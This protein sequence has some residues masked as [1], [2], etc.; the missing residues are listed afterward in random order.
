MKT[1]KCTS[2]CSQQPPDSCLFPACILAHPKTR[3]SYCRIPTTHKFDS[4]CNVVAKK[5]ITPLSQLK[6][7]P[8][9]LL[10]G[11]SGECIAFGKEAYLL[12]DFFDEP[13][14]VYSV[15]Q[16]HEVL[17][18]KDGFVSYALIT[19]HPDSFHEYWV[20]IHYINRILSR[21]PCFLYT[22]GLFY[23]PPTNKLPPLEHSTSCDKIPY[24]VT[25]HLH[26]AVPMSSIPKKERLPLLFIIYH[27]LATLSSTFTH[28]HL[29]MKNV[30]VWRPHPT[31]YIQYNYSVKFQSPYLPKITHCVSS[32][33]GND[34][35]FETIIDPTQDVSL[36]RE[37][38]GIHL[39]AKTT[40][41]EVYRM[42]KR[43]MKSSSYDV[44]GTLTV[45]KTTNSF[46]IDRSF[47]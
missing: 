38:M 29:T 26:D 8:D 19:S 6:R 32:F 18:L 39:P 23:S 44:V 47:L 31:L 37:A 27:A 34:S 30:M 2:S 21:F 12:R 11:E 17:Y 7:T 1:R 46:H 43:H 24:V 42:L 45:R 4:T 3:R 33:V 41:N 16:G 36:I 5:H 22:Y 10:R 35:C 15:P 25:Q 28:H 9:Y 14:E 20:G 40:V 13:E